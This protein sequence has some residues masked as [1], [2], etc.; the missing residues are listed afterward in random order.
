MTI[1]ASTLGGSLTLD[2]ESL[3]V[4][5]VESGETP[6]PFQ[7]D[8][9]THRLTIPHLPAR[10]GSVRVRFTGRVETE[11]ST[12][13]Y[14]TSLGEDRAL[15][16]MLAPASAR[17]VFPCLDRP[18]AKAV[19]ELEVLAPNDH[20]VISNMPAESTESLP[21][22]KRLTR[23][24]PTPRMSTY[25]LYLGV[26]PWEE[27][28]RIVEGFRVI[29]A[30]A[31]GSS[32]RTDEV[33]GVNGEALR[34]FSDYY[35]IPYP[36]PKLHLLAVPKFFSGAMENWGAIVAADSTA[37]LDAA[38]GAAELQG[39]MTMHIH[40][41]SHQWFGNLVTAVRWDDLWLNEGF[42]TFVSYK[43]AAALRPDWPSWPSFLSFWTSDAM[44]YDGLQTTH[45][46]STEVTDDRRAAEFFDGI[47]YGKGASILRMLEGY[48]GEADFRRGV[49]RYLREHREGNARAAD[50]WT[51]IAIESKEPI[52]RVMPPWILRPGFPVLRVRLDGSELVVDQSRF[53]YGARGGDPPWPVPLVIGSNGGTRRQLM[54]EPSVRLPGPRDG[55]AIVGPGRTGFYR[56]LYEGEL[57]RRFLEA[58][59]LLPEVD[60]W[61]FAD[62]A[63]AFFLSGEY[64]LREYR[65]A[66]ARV[67]E[68]P[69][70]V[71]A[72]G[73]YAAT[74]W[75]APL[76]QELPPL[77]EA[78][79]RVF[80]A[81]GE[82]LGLVARAGES[83]THATAR[84][85]VARSRVPLDTE[86]ALRLAARYPE[87]DQAAPE[88]REAILMAYAMT[89][90]RSAARDLRDRFRDTPPG[91]AR[92]Q[93]AGGLGMVGTDELLRES[94]AM[95]VDGEMDVGYWTHLSDNALWF[96]PM[97]YGGFWEFI[98]RD[99]ERS[100]PRLATGGWTMTSL[101]QVMIPAVGLN[102]PGP[103]RSWVDS[104]PLPEGGE[105]A[106]KGLEMLSVFSDVLRRARE[107][108][109]AA[110]A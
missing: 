99:L 75:M 73:A 67:E 69:S 30:A 34:Y 11:R 64:T 29:G 21:D 51:A 97:R 12:G 106:R 62:D 94:L 54:T 9:E 55:P 40:E 6:V 108:P 66:L 25:L 74:L 71:V 31:R 101:L 103:M 95:L 107:E 41:V 28:E 47:S 60:R 110:E 79:R 80:V 43:A 88:V 89:G 56:V 13:L 8:S 44:A 1:S 91:T 36:L 78:F 24:L 59:A 77:R 65:S 32:D 2:C 5:S 83:A 14:V 104:H 82:R 58:Y 76:W 22:G 27:R 81:H 90:G 26:G 68:D 42:A 102:R 39:L 93:V 3:A 48:V 35:G 96:N 105:A 37:L 63:R 87:V 53:A 7:Q 45:P 10:A 85:Q 98:T 23:F 70:P 109:A 18:D 16:T 20:T 4:G 33:L 17:R 49:S 52:D 61:G 57:R 15:T 84:D 72:G 46:V 50:L 100:A 38:V 86:F 92:R 19:I